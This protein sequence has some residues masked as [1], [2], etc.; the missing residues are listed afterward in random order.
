MSTFY[1]VE[2][3]RARNKSTSSY[4]ILGVV[5]NGVEGDKRGNLEDKTDRID[6]IFDDTLPNWAL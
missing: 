3:A 1:N 6:M 2:D 5:G 4:A